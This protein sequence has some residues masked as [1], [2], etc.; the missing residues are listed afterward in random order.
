MMRGLI[1]CIL[2]IC[3]SFLSAEEYAFFQEE[4]DAEGRVM[5]YCYSSDHQLL[6][7]EY[8][9]KND[10]GDS[11]LLYKKE[12]FIWER[13]EDLSPILVS[14]SVENEFS[15]ELFSHS[16]RYNA[17]GEIIEETVVDDTSGSSSVLSEETSLKPNDSDFDSLFQST[18]V[19]SYFWNY[20][21]DFFT[22]KIKPERVGLSDSVKNKLDEY[23][24]SFFGTTLWNF[25]GNFSGN[26]PIEWS[27]K[28]EVN[29]K[30]RVTFING[31]LN[32]TPMFEDSLELLSKTHGDVHIHSVFVGTQG[33]SRD[34]TRAI[35]L[36]MASSMGYRSKYAVML[37]GLWKRLINEM[38][39]VN[40]GGTII[41][42]A[43][44]LGG[45]ETDRARHFLSSEEQKMI[46]VTTLGSPTFILQ[47]GF[48]SVTNIVSA[49][50]GVGSFFL[51]PIGTIRYYLDERNATK[52]TGSI[53]S[54]AY[55]PFDHFLTGYTYGPEL[56]K[57][58][59]QFLEEFDKK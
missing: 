59:Q 39:G 43:H 35:L 22:S 19:L 33:W 7:V 23:C 17:L 49:N 2:L 31:I 45:T 1:Y 20:V 56:E 36:K 15:E 26:K 4:S 52:Y 55:F 54:G 38:G 28:R 3:F 29:N 37:A 18:D 51:E 44:S 25:M 12:T 50:D 8:Y 10:S 5:I 46:R 41:H 30:V 14:H 57:F 48:Q 6:A 42:Y 53:F 11:L 32:T 40:G 58:G 24:S 47:Q 16:F 27:G 13:K 21:Q 34:I 9:Q